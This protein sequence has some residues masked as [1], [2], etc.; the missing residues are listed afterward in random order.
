MLKFLVDHDHTT[1]SLEAWAG[2]KKLVTASFFFWNPGTDMQKSQ[3]GLLQSLLY[4]IFRQCPATIPLVCPS[5]WQTD[6][7]QEHNEPWTRSE[8]WHAFVEIRKQNLLSTRFCFFIDGLDEY[9]GDHAEIIA[10]M[11][12]FATQSDVKIC[13]SSRPWNVFEDTF[14]KNP[15]RTLALHEFTK[16]DIR[17]YVRDKLEEDDRF[18]KLK[19]EDDRY[20][21]LV[22]EITNRAEGVFLWVFLV[23]RSLLQGLNNSDTIADFQRRLRLLPTDLEKYFRHMLDSTEKVYHEQA[24][25]IFQICLAA[26][27]SLSL[28]T[29]SYFDEEDP[30]YAIKMEVQ[31]LDENEIEKKCTQLS[32]RVKA[33][34]KDL[35]VLETTQGAPL[36]AIFARKVDFLHRTVRD[37][38][39]T[40]DMQVLL[41]DRIDT[42][43]DANNYL[44]KAYLAQLKR[45]PHAPSLTKFGPIFTIVDD[46][47][48]H[49]LQCEVK[50]MNSNL[51]LLEAFD[52]VIRLH[53][54]SEQASFW[55]SDWQS[56][57][58]DNGYED[59]WFV[60]AA[61]QYGLCRYVEKKL[62]GAKIS[63]LDVH[64]R[65]L[66]DFALRPPLQS[67]YDIDVDPEMVRLLLDSGSDPNRLYD[68]ESVWGHFLIS[69]HQKRQWAQPEVKHMWAQTIEMLLQKGAKPTIRCKTGSTSEKPTFSG[70]AVRYA[71]YSS[72]LDVI[73]DTCL[74]RD[75]M[76]LKEVLKE[77][78]SSGFFKWIG[79]L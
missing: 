39:Q 18:V 1:K 61:I 49:A 3:E 27:E 60:A 67:T 41:M 21:D 11:E 74:S 54:R 29:L 64:D 35:I 31:P 4:S 66:L 78:T 50:S 37:F 36:D 33:R 24:A 70:R 42:R 14:G 45:I 75:A 51:P 63:T 52:Q 57:L 73:Q 55:Q 69:I 38:L 59:G 22:V 72:V 77:R 9:E 17:L 23:V 13:L 12:E 48:Y 5:R 68:G 2:E 10:I 32:K 43:F 65:P 79:I 26:A 34:C 28:M 7:Q 44:C 62:K 30:D 15:E 58:L 6:L 19:S 47:M 40:K 71:V 25:K 8:L 53:R 76:H 20:K 46:F 56:L 16:K